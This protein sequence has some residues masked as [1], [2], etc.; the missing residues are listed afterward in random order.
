MRVRLDRIGKNSLPHLASI[1]S[2]RFD[3]N[4][5]Q[6]GEVQIGDKC[7]VS[8]GYSGVVH[9]KDF[10]QYVYHN[11]EH[12]RPSIQFAIVADHKGSF[13][14]DGDSGSSI[15]LEGGRA[16][17]TFVG[18]GT[19]FKIEGDVE[20]EFH[21]GY[22]VPLTWIFERIRDALGRNLEIPSR[23]DLERRADGDSYHFWRTGSARVRH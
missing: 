12:D 16:G 13:G 20:I 7:A 10:D 15:A 6:M 21:Y 5:D 4:Y 3:A 23:H 17:G 19:A 11:D 2:G 18:G 1:P 22:M 8:G 14:V 9:G